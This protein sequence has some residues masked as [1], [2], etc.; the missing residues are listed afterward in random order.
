MIGVPPI[1]CRWC[2]HRQSVLATDCRE[3]DEAYS[4]RSRRCRSDVT[5]SR[6]TIAAHRGKRPICRGSR[7]SRRATADGWQDRRR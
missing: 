7:L 6:L 3:P 5:I 1:K 4:R 2:E